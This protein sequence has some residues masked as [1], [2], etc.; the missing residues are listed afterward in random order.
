[1]LCSSSPEKLKNRLTPLINS[2]AAHP[3]LDAILLV[4][5]KSQRF[6]YPSLFKAFE[7][8][9]GFSDTGKISAIGPITINKSN[10]LSSFSI[11]HGPEEI[12][13][14]IR[15]IFIG[16]MN[17][18]RG[19]YGL[20]D[21]EQIEELIQ[22]TETFKFL[23]LYPE[24]GVRVALIFIYNERELNKLYKK[25]KPSTNSKAILLLKNYVIRQE[26]T[27]E[28]NSNLS[29]F[30]TQLDAGRQ[31]IISNAIWV[32][33]WL[34]EQKEIDEE[35]ALAMTCC[36]LLEFSKTFHA[37]AVAP[38]DHP[39]VARLLENDECLINIF[40][41]LF[42]GFF[43]YDYH[44][45]ATRLEIGSQIIIDLNKLML[46][47]LLIIDSSTRLY[48]ANP[49]ITTIIRCFVRSVDHEWVNVRAWDVLIQILCKIPRKTLSTCVKETQTMERMI[50]IEQILLREMEA[51]MC[52]LS[53]CNRE[54]LIV[55]DISSHLDT[56]IALVNFTNVMLAADDRIRSVFTKKQHFYSSLI[57]YIMQERHDLLMHSCEPELIWKHASSVGGIAEMVAQISRGASTS[58]GPVLARLGQ[59]ETEQYSLNILDRLL[60]GDL[61][62][63][64]VLSSV[65]S[66]L[67]SLPLAT[68]PRTPLAFLKTMQEIR[69][70]LLNDNTHSWCFLVPNITEAIETMITTLTFA[71]RKHFINSP[72]NAKLTY[73]CLWMVTNQHLNCV[74][75]LEEGVYP[76]HYERYGMLSTCCNR[77]DIHLLKLA[78]LLLGANPAWKMDI[79]LE[80]V[81]APISTSQSFKTRRFARLIDG[82][83]L[84]QAAERY[85]D[86]L[87]GY[88][89]GDWNGFNE[90][91]NA[92][93]LVGIIDMIQG[94]GDTC[95]AL[96]GKIRRARKEYEP[97]SERDMGDKPFYKVHSPPQGVSYCLVPVVAGAGNGGA[98]R[99]GRGSS[100]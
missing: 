93:Y 38:G 3:L 25:F 18:C 60:R 7:S 83:A 82:A 75:S 36:W 88:E 5:W 47:V 14:I 49:L 95:K 32:L 24:V 11:E 29:L 94:T 37:V 16:W 9:Y 74:L 64:Y 51:V 76:Q 19:L 90:L 100:R 97:L 54:F 17:D 72:W 53:K 61:D 89:Y 71:S 50:L 52:K 59:C 85:L 99:T 8:L 73:K 1:M 6:A 96:K 91:L 2:F 45:S 79:F 65:S 55:Q 33:P 31:C 23:I 39:H 13:K 67:S 77:V 44:I 56:L 35:F 27:V 22:N 42:H 46:S 69:Y 43:C 34:W 41:E 21:P 4:D 70:L 87:G 30:L 92:E 66:L 58:I 84:T 86:R 57:K 63:G 48:C 10:F 28:K 12:K 40:I 81:Q 78:S 80:N 20:E 68:I 62:K 98:M 26:A 15:L